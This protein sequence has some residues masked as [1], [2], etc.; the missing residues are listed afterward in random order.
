MK[1]TIAYILIILSFSVSAT[2]QDKIIGTWSYTLKG[3]DFTENQTCSFNGDASFSCVIEEVG[4]SN[5]FGD[6]HKYKTSGKWSLVNDTLTMSYISPVNLFNKT[7]TV[8]NIITGELTLISAKNYKEIWQ[9]ISTA[10]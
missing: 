8:S 10:N 4:Y 9:A 7:Y 3:D 2:Y 5:G 6:A 1:L